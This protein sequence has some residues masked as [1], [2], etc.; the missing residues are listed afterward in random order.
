M[1]RVTWLVSLSVLLGIASSSQAQGL[2]PNLPDGSKAHRDLEYVRGGHER[3]RL[4]LYL[5]E[6]A[7]RPL[8]VIVWVHGGAW[9]AGS[10]DPRLITRGIDDLGAE[11]P[12]WL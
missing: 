5:P 11:H 7:D 2:R 1:E 4:D 12:R 10:K 6:K 8:P 9:L 3:Q